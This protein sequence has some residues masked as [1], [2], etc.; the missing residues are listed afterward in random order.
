MKKIKERILK[1][2]NLSRDSGATK[3]E[4][5]TAMLK[6]Q[7]YMVKHGIQE[8]DV[9]NTDNQKLK[10]MQVTS[11]KRL[12]WW[13]LR[14]GEIIADNFKCISYRQKY[15]NL[16]TVKFL[17]KEKDIEVTMEIFYYGL[18]MIEYYANKI[19]SD[20]Y[21]ETDE[22]MKKK[23]VNTYITGYLDGLKSKFK[24]QVKNNEWGLILKRDKS[25][26]DYAKDELNLRKFNL[27][28]QT[29]N[30]TKMYDKGFKQGKKF[31]MIKGKIEQG[32]S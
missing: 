2:L 3:Q 31:E 18:E 21:I 1:L 4:S 13:H 22:R 8:S 14:L 28:H 27:K 7:E 16:S 30:D 32:G 24:E 15:G 25:V 9:Y 20:H 29:D 19:K 17:G 23:T 6:A 5:Q 11:Y 10:T 26:D 12:V